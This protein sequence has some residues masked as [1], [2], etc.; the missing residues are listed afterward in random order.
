M[1]DV[2]AVSGRR[3][4]SLLCA[5]AACCPEIG[6]PILDD[7]DSLRVAAEC[8]GAGWGICDDPGPVGFRGVPARGHPA[9]RALVEHWAVDSGFVADRRRT[10]DQ[11]WAVLDRAAAPCDTAAAPGHDPLPAAAELARLVGAAHGRPVRDALLARMA[12]SGRGRDTTWLRWTAVLRPALL[13]APAGFRAGI[14][15]LAA[16]ADW[17]AGMTAAALGA[18][19]QGLADRPEDRLCSLLRRAIAGGLP[20]EHWAE[21]ASRLSEESCLAFTARPS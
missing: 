4:R 13:E 3:W 10:L 6:R 1:R 12:R 18:V 14:A 20:A 9:V 8:V 19:E 17:Q 5:D 11:A 15:A 2:L 21:A 16:V 7:G